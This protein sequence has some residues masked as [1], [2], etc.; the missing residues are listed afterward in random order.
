[1]T[2]T[3]EVLDEYRNQTKETLYICNFTLN[4]C[5]TSKKKNA[6]EQ[7]KS[8]EAIKNCLELRIKLV[9]YEKLM[10][11]VILNQNRSNIIK[12]ITNLREKFLSAST[13]YCELQREITS[14]G[15]VAGFNENR[16]IDCCKDIKNDVAYFTG[17]CDS[18]IAKY[19]DDNMKIIFKD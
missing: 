7:I 18:I 10:I 13:E 1:M 19:T 14:M 11:N 9:D 8:L 4:S 6:K 15:K 12:I 3:L 16:F 17:V 5:L 2:S